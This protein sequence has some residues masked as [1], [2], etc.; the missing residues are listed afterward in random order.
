MIPKN[1]VKYIA[2]M[3]YVA[4]FR[5]VVILIKLIIKMDGCYMMMDG[6]NRLTHLDLKWDNYQTTRPPKS[7]LKS[8]KDKIQ[9][10]LKLI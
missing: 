5:A 7:N 1:Y 4:M 3:I 8:I 10:I 9:F 2:N 6:K